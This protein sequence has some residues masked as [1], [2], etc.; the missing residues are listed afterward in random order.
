MS[1]WVADALVLLGV[2]VMTVGVYGVFRMPDVYTE[3]HAASKAVFLGVVVLLVASTVTGDGAIIARAALI[4][5]FLVLT[6]PVA[7]HVIALAAYRQEERMETPGALDE[8]GHDLPH[9]RAARPD[10]EPVAVD[11]DGRRRL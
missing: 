3:L 7:A 4:G 6:T 8:S 5:V 11:G 10:S 9:G 2:V 1:A